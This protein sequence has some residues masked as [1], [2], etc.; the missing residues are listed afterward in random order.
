MRERKYHLYLSED[1]RR[2]HS[3]SYLVS[4]QTATGRTLY[5]CRRRLDSQN[6]KDKTEK[7]QGKIERTGEGI[8]AFSGFLYQCSEQTV[9]TPTVVKQCFPLG[10][11][12]NT[13]IYWAAA[14]DC[15][16]GTQ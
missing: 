16:L 15:K 9:C 14:F 5:R 10:C 2:F 11:C 12:P 3:K 13:H 1:E 8:A 6:F 7:N 4:E